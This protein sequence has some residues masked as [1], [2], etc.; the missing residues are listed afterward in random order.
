MHLGPGNSQLI[1]LMCAFDEGNDEYEQVSAGQL[2]ESLESPS[3]L[4]EYKQTL[5]ILEELLE[6]R[7]MN[8]AL[9][10]QI[11]QV[12]GQSV[13][14][15]A[16][17]GP[18]TMSEDKAATVQQSTKA[19][20]DEPTSLK[21]PEGMADVTS[22]LFKMYTKKA[23]GATVNINT[24]QCT[25]QECCNPKDEEETSVVESVFS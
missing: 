4:L 11:Q 6:M 16:E 7:G 13:G 19:D 1:S 24:R 18:H 15:E 23:G 22:Q 8:D 20:Q 10:L 5:Q 14:P 9:R 2:Q 25:C 17:Q 3:R 21:C 12:T